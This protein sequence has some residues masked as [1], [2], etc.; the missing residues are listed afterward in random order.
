MHIRQ[1]STMSYLTHFCVGNYILTHS[2]GKLIY[3]LH[4]SLK[5]G[6]L[7]KIKFRANTRYLQSNLAY[8]NDQWNYSSYSL[9]TTPIQWGYVQQMIT[10]FGNKTFPNFKHFIEEQIDHEIISLWEQIW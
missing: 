9:W 5:V 7:K 1:K 8:L 10:N 3:S 6:K 4:F 2:L